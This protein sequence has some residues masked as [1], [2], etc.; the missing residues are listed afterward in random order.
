[1]SAVEKKQRDVITIEGITYDI[2]EFKHPGGNIINYAKNLADSTEIF[3]EFHHRSS[4]AK[5]VLRSLPHYNDGPENAPELPPERQLTQREREMTADFREMRSTLV[6]E[7]CFEPD[8]I[9]VYFRLLELAFYLGVGTWLASYNTYMSLLSF[10]AFKTRCG[11]VQHECGHLSFT[12]NRHLDRAIQ[13]FTMGFGDG[14][15]SS[16]WNSMHQKHHATPQKVKYDIDLD[17]TPFVAFFNRAFEENPNSKFASRFMNRWWMRFQAWTFLPVVNGIF[18]QLFWLYYLHPKKVFRRLCSAKSREVCLEAVF[19]VLCMSLFHIYIPMIY[20]RYA[21]YGVIYSYFLFMVTNFWNFI[22]MFG[23]FSLSHTFTEVVSEHDNLLW[24]EYAIQHS[25]NIS[26]N[27]QLVTWIM[28]YLNFQIE[29]HLFPSMPQYKNAFAARYVRRFC[30]KWAPHLKYVEHS[31]WDAWWLMLSNLNTVGKHY[32][33]FGVSIN[34]T[35]VSPKATETIPMQ[36]QSEECDNVS[37]ESDP[38][39]L[40]LD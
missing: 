1:M 40:H 38:E 18:V 2:T 35:E 31:Y 21:G 16:V 3:N 36:E 22:Y 26:T 13:T 9:H 23:H 4:K 19:E 34:D 20:T 12:G 30:D 39:H 25:V 17:T 5:K 7:G 37:S 10:I 33:S 14:L 8:Y 6:E 11:W 27:S 15:S 32:Y 28:G 29:H 24:F